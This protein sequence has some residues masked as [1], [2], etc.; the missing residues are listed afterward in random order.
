MH[1]LQVLVF[2]LYE[3]SMTDFNIFKR[4]RERERVCVCVLPRPANGSP[5]MNN[6]ME[7]AATR[8]ESFPNKKLRW[9]LFSWASMTA[10]FFL[11]L[12][13]F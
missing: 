5:Q 11:L 3:S 8:V 10:W 6:L 4:E 7:V 13:K 2:N 9:F 12:P 1:K